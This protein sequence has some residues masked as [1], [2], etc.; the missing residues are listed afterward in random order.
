[1]SV[2]INGS[3]SLTGITELSST[4]LTIDGNSLSTQPS[5]RNLI[6]NGDMRIAQRATSKTG[7]ISTDWPTID[8]YR[9]INSGSI[10]TW[11]NTQSTDVPTGQGFTYSNKLECTAT[12]TLTS[13]SQ[14]RFEHRIEA[15][16]LQHLKFGTSNA[17]SLTIS[18][19]VKSNKT[20]D[21]VVWFY[22]Q[23]SARQTNKVYTINSADTWEKKTLTITGDTNASAIINND[24]GIGFMVCFPLITGSDLTSGTSPDGTW[25]GYSSANAWAGQTVT[26]LGDSTSN[27]IN[28]TGIQLEVGENATPFEHRPYDVEL[29][30]CQRYC[31]VIS[32]E[33][34]TANYSAFGYGYN[35]SGTRHECICHLP[36]K[37][38]ATPSLTITASEWQVSSVNTAPTATTVAIFGNQ[39][40]TNSVQ[41]YADTS[42]LTQAYP[43]RLETKG[44]T[45]VKAILSAEL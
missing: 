22:A 10:G 40:S 34:S 28:F 3:G 17:E 29:A 42:G 9:L 43:G 27:Y 23:D 35:S 4:E 41:V 15:Q 16:N 31:T 8:R 14:W 5:F 38:R 36:T 39:S 26:N 19:W 30:R 45:T 21:Y 24:N 25:Q 44:S 20:G 37:M 18:F 33:G 2:T 1:M 12:A 11:T 7:I 13:S 32:G 6:I